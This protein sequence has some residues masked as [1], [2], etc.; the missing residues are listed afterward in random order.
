LRTSSQRPAAGRTPRAPWSAIRERA[1]PV[2]TGPDDVT[3]SLAQKPAQATKEEDDEE[4]RIEP[5]A[6]RPG[7]CERSPRSASDLDDVP[8]DERASPELRRTDQQADATRAASINH[9]EGS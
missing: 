9:P 4:R 7:D 5:G 6:G 8:A 3:I 1:R 2:R